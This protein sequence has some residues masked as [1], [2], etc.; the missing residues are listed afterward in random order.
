ME[1]TM[2]PPLTR[3]FFLQYEGDMDLS[4]S[5]T[6][7]SLGRWF[8]GL[9]QLVRGWLGLVVCSVKENT[10][11]PQKLIFSPWKK[12][13]KYDSIWL[14]VSKQVFNNGTTTYFFTFQSVHKIHQSL[15]KSVTS[16]NIAEMQ[17]STR[18]FFMRKKNIFA[19]R[20][21]DFLQGKMFC[22][23][24]VRHTHGLHFKFLCIWEW[25]NGEV[26]CG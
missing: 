20:T 9:V 16:S 18:I 3:R 14:E 2:L 26:S 6:K 15:K 17:N 23:K 11:P 7:K 13:A 4:W 12:W 8:S 1:R 21:C 10:I 24:C 22:K 25:H 19:L 5:C